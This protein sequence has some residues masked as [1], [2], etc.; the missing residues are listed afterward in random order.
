MHLIIWTTLGAVQY[1][2][3][4]RAGAESFF[5]TKKSQ[6]S[7]RH[8]SAKI[9]G[10]ANMYMKKS[11]GLVGVLTVAHSLIQLGSGGAVSPPASTGQVSGGPGGEA[12]ESSKDLVFYNTKM[13]INSKI[14]C[15]FEFLGRIVPSC[16]I[17]L[18]KNLE[19]SV[20]ILVK[21]KNNSG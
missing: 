4:N 11:V 20:P 7:C 14:I 17:R 5:G 10:P 19:K 6:D 12:S 9:I 1:L 15:I 13:I 21:V 16:L 8:N 2:L 18:Q 3:Y